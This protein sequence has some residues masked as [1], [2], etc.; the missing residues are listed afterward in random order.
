[1]SVL[2]PCFVAAVRAVHIAL[3]AQ[4]HEEGFTPAPVP[5]SAWLGAVLL[6]L[7]GVMPEDLMT[8][9]TCIVTG[10][11][12]LV[13]PVAEGILAGIPRCVAS[14]H[15][16]G[17]DHLVV[18]QDGLPTTTWYAAALKAGAPVAMV[19]ATGFEFEPQEAVTLAGR[20]VEVP[21]A[22]RGHIL[23]MV[24]EA[25]TGSRIHVRDEDAALIGWGDIV[26]VAQPGSDH[27]AVAD[28]I[29]KLARSRR[30]QGETG[31]GRRKKGAAA[32]P[33]AAAA[34]DG[35]TRR[36]ADMAGF[37]GDARSWGM[38]LAEDLNGY[39]S[40]M[41]EWRDVDHGALLSGPPGCGKTTFAKSL[42]LECELELVT[43]TYNEWSSLGGSGDSMSKGMSKLFDNWRA[44]VKEG[45]FILFIDEIDSMGQR[46][47]AAHNESWFA[48]V[49][50]AWLAFLD[51]ATPRDG[52]VVIAATN[53]PS[54]VD[55]AL[56]RAG[57]L[58]RHIVLPAPAPDA[59]ASMLRV[60]LG[61]EASL[62]GLSDTARACRGMSPADI[63]L[64]VRDARR[65]ARTTFRRAV[66][67]DDVRTVL[68]TRRLRDGIGRRLDH[69]IAVHEAGHAVAVLA[70]GVD[71]LDRV[72]LD[73][74]LTWTAPPQ[75][76]TLAD[77]EGRLTMQLA[78]MAA[79]EALLGEHSAGCTL[80][81]REA[82]NLASSIHAAWGMG[83]SGVLAL[84]ADMVLRERRT[85][86]AV[87]ATLAAAHG[88]ARA[89]VETHRDAIARVAEA[90]VERRYLDAEEV[91]EV[92]G[93]APD[94]EVA[95]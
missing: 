54:R 4:A 59:L 1:M 27:I 49:I 19:T 3:V 40:G 8:G 92:I 62:D 56:S 88:R 17:P 68:E 30:A 51:G 79:E 53:Y 42:A 78:G 20:M 48:P 71:T 47:G 41:L 2:P 87:E 85:R 95:R 70:L 7:A 82:C 57:R 5:S 44:K 77:V 23:G 66:S 86:E 35:V 69:R 28:R 11:A 45:P 9:T 18:A 12:A 22:P 72:D 74:A 36:L 60:H 89:L 21:P 83:A 50:N 65:L 67:A 80:D 15:R 81:L 16:A 13:G 29:R 73:A 84:P 58:D 32:A 10:E 76:W 52:I 39:R 37:G 33:A 38:A 94:L 64:V 6:D 31:K 75:G 25:A 34:G 61:P 26:L 46:G 24:V 43:T 14:G 93:T 55:P 90:L 63:A 91:R